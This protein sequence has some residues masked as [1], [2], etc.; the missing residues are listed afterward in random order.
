[1]TQIDWYF[2]HGWRVVLW[3]QIGDSKGPTQKG[4]PDKI[5]KKEDY[6]D[7]YRIGVITGQEISPGRYLHDVD[8]DWAPGANIALAFLPTTDFVFG[9]SSK[10]ISH[11]FYTLP[12]PVV[13]VKYED[14][15]KTTLLE[16]RG[17]KQSG[18]LGMQTMVPPSIWSK[19]GKR[20]PLVF[21]KNGDPSHQ[22]S[23]SRL[24]QSVCLGAIGMLIAKHLGHHGFGHEPRLAWAGF[25]LRAGIDPEDVILM[26]ERISIFCDNTEVGD[27]RTVVESTA[28]GMAEKG[29]KIKGA[30]AL[31]KIIGDKGKAVIARINEW[32]GRDSDFIRNG[33]GQIIKDNQEN[34]RRAVVQ[35]GVELAYNEFADRKTIDT[36]TGRVLLDDQQLTRLYLRIDEECR[37]RPSFAFFNMVI[38]D[39]VWNNPYHPVKDYFRT[40]VWDGQPR[41][42]TWLVTYAGAEDSE[43][44]R[45]ISSI[46]L[47]AAVRRILQPG[48]KYDEMLVLESNTQGMSKSSAIRALCPNDDWFSDDLALN[49]NSQK[50]MEA[51]MGKWIIEAADLAGK[52]KAEVEQLKATLS[53]QIDGPARMA[54]AR[55]PQERARQFIIIGTTNSNHY[56]TDT[57]G[58]RRF[59][60]VAID[61]FDIEGIVLDRDQ[62]WA[63]A[64]VRESAGESIRLKEELWG[65]AGLEQEKRREIDAWEDEIVHFLENIKPSDSDGCKRVRTSVLW[66][67]LGIEVARRD[68]SHS[69]RL[70]EVM[71]KLGYRSSTIRDPEDGVCRGWI[72]KQEALAYGG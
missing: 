18:E 25:M 38:D 22:D 54:Y 70:S 67:A 44:L 28:R 11:C 2:E 36:G 19:D 46:V 27:V 4:W 62:L 10:R 68:R 21:A 50:M 34:I 66:E 49:V 15:D 13:S 24:K 1:M 30:P 8:I 33:D 5:F 6:Q 32:L 59:W 23:V 39:T 17:V 64:L 29:K 47:I 63:E 9:R 16:L 35:L 40:L 55:A 69:I 65:A 58:A 37:F 14:V 72:G 26:G 60:P 45:A 51:T 52:R 41:I 31:A 12:E 43:Y 20:E 3:P 53:R 42:D 57:T 61:R 56:L 71:H 48:C 7:G